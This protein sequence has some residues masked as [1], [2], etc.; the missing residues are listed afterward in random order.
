MIKT[1][2]ETKS[3]KHFLDMIKGMHEKSTAN[4]FIASQH[5]S[6]KDTQYHLPSG[7]CK[8]KASELPVQIC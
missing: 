4:K 8:L 2:H 6:P 1:I 3:R 5:R 7:K